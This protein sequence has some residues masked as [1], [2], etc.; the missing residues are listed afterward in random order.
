MLA[1]PVNELT[2]LL[3]I[4][5]TQNVGNILSKNICQKLI[6]LPKILSDNKDSNNVYNTNKHHFSRAL[7]LPPLTT[8]LVVLVLFYITMLLNLFCTELFL[9]WVHKNGTKL[10]FGTFQLDQISR[11]NLTGNTPL[12]FVTQFRC[13]NQSQLSLQLNRRHIG[14][15]SMFCM[16]LLEICN[17]H[18]LYEND[19]LISR[20][21]KET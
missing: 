3:N 11:H 14:S 21:I 2:Y 19:F 18:L 9:K 7:F 15:D 6:N 5:Y 20:F 1:C 10:L 16:F 8:I 12:V 13:L 17:F 4:N